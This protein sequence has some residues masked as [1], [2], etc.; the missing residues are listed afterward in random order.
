MTVRSKEG[1]KGQGVAVAATQL[2]CS[3]V[4]CMPVTTPAIKVGSANPVKILLEFWVSVTIRSKEG[5]S[6][7]G[8]SVGVQ[9]DHLYGYYS[10]QSR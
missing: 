4:I 2:G 7:S 6:C 1:K 8:C 9:R 10:P 3:A 5:E